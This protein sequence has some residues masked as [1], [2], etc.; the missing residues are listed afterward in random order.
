MDGTLRLTGHS[1]RST[2]AQGL[3]SIGW[4]PDAVQLQGRWQSETVRIYTR[5]AA[6]HAPDDLVALVAA[7]CG[8]T[9]EEVPPPP[10]PEPEPD[11]PPAGDW[12]LNVHTKM[13]HL[14]STVEG[15]AR[16]GWLYAESGIRGHEP[17]PWHIVTCKQCVPV[18]RRRLKA[19]A[20]DAAA[21]VRRRSLP[22]EDP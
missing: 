21:S 14:A 7:L 9:R 8:V 2:G 15:R 6:L 4:R 5:D 17:P 16:C 10:A 22:I 12:V 18:R 13:Y 20:R 1:L 19:A 11:N 3:I